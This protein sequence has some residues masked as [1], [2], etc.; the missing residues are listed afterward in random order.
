MQIVFNNFVLLF[1]LLIT[2][3]GYCFA[4]VEIISDNELGDFIATEGVCNIKVVEG[5]NTS[6]ELKLVMGLNKTKIDLP[7]ITNNN[8]TMEFM[9][10]VSDSIKVINVKI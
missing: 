4:E 3:C 10:K 2:F 1:I 9:P 7:N 5:C 6:S 8:I